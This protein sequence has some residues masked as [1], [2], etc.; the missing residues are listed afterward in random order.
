MCDFTP[1]ANFRVFFFTL[2]TNFHA[3]FYT[4]RDFYTFLLILYKKNTVLF[5]YI[6]MNFT[7]L[8]FLLLFFNTIFYDFYTM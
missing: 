1:L 4:I 5:V 8:I 7:E 3:W 6:N 2:F